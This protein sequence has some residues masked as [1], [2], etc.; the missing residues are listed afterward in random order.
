MNLICFP[1]YTC[2]GLLCDILQQTFSDVGA[3]GGIASTNHNLG[4]IGDADDILVTYDPALLYKKLDSFNLKDTDWVT[5][6]CHPRL[7]DFSKFDSII[8]VTTTTFKSKIYRW[9]RAYHHYYYNSVPWTSVSGLDRIDKERETAKNYLKPFFPVIAD[10]ITNIEFSEIVENTEIFKKL[11]G[12]LETEKHLI[13]WRSLNS[14]LYNAKIWS[15]DSVTRFY[16]AEVEVN[17]GIQY[18]YN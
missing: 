7:L 4:K 6:H 1:H 16:E 12:D 9:V 5:T 8:V 10:N 11:V 2:G 15:Q 3:N 13:R 18:L 17:L 14:F